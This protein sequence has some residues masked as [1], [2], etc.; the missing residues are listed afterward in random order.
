MTNLFV[1]F[2][3]FST[4]YKLKSS[5]T[6]KISSSVQEDPRVE[7]ALN[8]FSNGTCTF[9]KF[10]TTIDYSKIRENR[11]H[12]A[13]LLIDYKIKDIFVRNKVINSNN[14]LSYVYPLL[15]RG[16]GNCLVSKTS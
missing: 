8:G 5:E 10:T 7:E 6:T 9:H 2:I 15:T 12:Y 16:D 3:E 14:R 11:K 13:K 1:N 4:N